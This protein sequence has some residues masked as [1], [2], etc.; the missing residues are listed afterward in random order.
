MLDWLWLIPTLPLAGFTF[1]APAGGRLS[2]RG[3]AWAARRG[4][5]GSV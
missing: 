3:I 1:L 5:S 2:R 4:R